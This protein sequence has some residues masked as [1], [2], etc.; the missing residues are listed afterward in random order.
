MLKQSMF[1]VFN[2]ARP[3]ICLQIRFVFAHCRWNITKSVKDIRLF[4]FLCLSYCPN[5]NMNTILTHTINKFTPDSQ[6][7]LNDP[8][9]VYSPIMTVVRG[10]NSAGVQLS[11]GNRKKTICLAASCHLYIIQLRHLP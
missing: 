5:D 3:C 10:H 2:I 4:I 8:L 11:C 7:T 1:Q 9:F 6:K